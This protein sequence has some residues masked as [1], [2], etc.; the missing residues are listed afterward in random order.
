MI[1]ESAIREG[2]ILTSPLFSEPMRVVTVRA[3]GTDYLEAGLVGQR[4]EQF[5][6]VSLSSADI[7]NLTIADAALSYDGD[8]RLLRIGLQ[9]Y[10]LGIAYEFD[11]SE[12]PRRSTGRRPAC[13][14]GR[15]PD[16]AIP[17]AP[18]LQHLRHA[19]VA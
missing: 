11:P 15:F 4:S 6:Q 1:V 2:Q 12:R 7:S 10:A 19:A 9:A 13:S 14:G 16:V 5:R 18:C 3:N 8:G 17:A